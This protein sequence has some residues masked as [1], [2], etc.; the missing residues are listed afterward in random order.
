MKYVYVNGLVPQA[1][2]GDEL[3]VGGNVNCGRRISVNA[4]CCELSNY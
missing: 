4:C 2:K 1:F 3:F